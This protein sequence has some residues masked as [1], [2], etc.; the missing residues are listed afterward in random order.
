MNTREWGGEDD[1]EEIRK[2]S[3]TKHL[4]STDFWEKHRDSPKI[5]ASP[6]KQADLPLQMNHEDES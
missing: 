5:L 1:V 3:D 4:F 6:P 2:R